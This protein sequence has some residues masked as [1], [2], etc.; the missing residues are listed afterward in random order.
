[1][2]YQ[3]LVPIGVC[4]VLPIMIVWLTT[5][6]K[7]N[8][9]KLRAQIIIEAIKNN[10]NVDPKELAKMFQPE[11][12]KEKD[13]LAKRLQHGMVC[14]LLGLSG[15]AGALII[16]Y[17]GYFTSEDLMVMMFLSVVVLAVGISTLVRFF[18]QRKQSQNEQPAEEEQ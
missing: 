11:Q 14:T 1:M 15:I 2:L 10:P 17:L 16:S 4:V 8:A 5:R 3:V 6:T 12:K 9:D 7:I 13:S 18:Y